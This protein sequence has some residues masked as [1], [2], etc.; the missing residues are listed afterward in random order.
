MI[1]GYL[2]SMGSFFRMKSL[3]QGDPVPFVLNTTVGN[4]IALA[5]SFFLSGPRTQFAKMF[6]DSR[7]TATLL[8]L[9]SL[10]STLVITILTSSS[11]SSDDGSSSSRAAFLLLM[12]MVLCQY[13]AITWYTLSYIPFAREI[14][15][16]FVQ[17]RV[18]RRGGG[19]SGVGY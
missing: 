7:R 5:G 2:L 15:S 17:R 1:A 11:S 4:M 10:F 12:I 6:H 3:F 8:Y 18:N 19:S 9:G 13:V 14:V 16:G